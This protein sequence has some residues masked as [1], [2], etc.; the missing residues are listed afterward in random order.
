[1]VVPNAVSTLIDSNIKMKINVPNSIQLF[2]T[3]TFRNFLLKGFTK[4]NV[5]R[6][7]HGGG[8]LKYLATLNNMVGA[9]VLTSSRVRVISE[10]GQSAKDSHS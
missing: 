2:I 6:G 4:L 3:C 9:V 10:E 7:Y 8:N 1:M 5:Q